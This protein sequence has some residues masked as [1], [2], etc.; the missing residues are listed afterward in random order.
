MSFGL[1]TR[2]Q[3]GKVVFRMDSNTFLIRS[4]VFY[5]FT[6]SRGTTQ[7]F[8]LAHL[9]SNLILV[10]ARTVEGWILEVTVSGSTATVREPSYGFSG[11]TS[12]SVRFG[13]LE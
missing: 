1:E 12:A 8:N 13:V 5:T 6:I 11:T 10:D 9:G 2:D 7:T 4:F 3:N